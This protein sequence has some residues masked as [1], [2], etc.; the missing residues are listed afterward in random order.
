[1]DV[2][3]FKSR[4]RGFS[5]AIGGGAVL[6]SRFDRDARRRGSRLLQTL[7]YVIWQRVTAG[8]VGPR[9]LTCHYHFNCGATTGV[10]LPIPDHL[11]T[12]AS[13]NAPPCSRGWLLHE[14]PLLHFFLA[15]LSST[16]A[17]MPCKAHYCTYL[18]L[19]V[20]SLPHRHKVWCGKLIKKRETSFVTL[21]RNG[22]KR[23]YL[24]EKT[25]LSL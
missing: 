14:S 17:K 18:L 25:I 13:P 7:G 20:L 11:H 24:G 22:A 15:S 8:Q 1:M 21:G 2:V 5:Y 23:V 9:D 6:P 19:Q 10:S 3:V 16:Y 4:G 12:G